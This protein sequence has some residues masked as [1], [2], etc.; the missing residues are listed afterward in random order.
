[1]SE[2]NKKQKTHGPGNPRPDPSPEET[3][4]RAPEGGDAEVPHAPNP[5]RNG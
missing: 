5:E 4:P 1:M 2:Q 3:P